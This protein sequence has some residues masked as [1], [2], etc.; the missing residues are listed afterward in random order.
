M[1]SKVGLALLVVSVTLLAFF[2][3]NR[4]PQ[5]KEVANEP[6]RA[7]QTN[8][9]FAANEELKGPLNAVCKYASEDFVAACYVRPKNLAAHEYYNALPIYSLVP[10][11]VSLTRLNEMQVEEL[12]VFAGTA[13]KDSKLPPES[14][15]SKFQL[16]LAGRFAERIEPQTLIA[17]WTQST[18]PSHVPEPTPHEEIKI[19]DRQCYRVPAG[20]FLECLPSFIVVGTL[21]VP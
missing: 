21:R 1:I 19:G 7:T 10:A 14:L 5:S 13:A 16:A 15:A 8:A 18:P 6:Q 4:T 12:V 9:L 11:S 17:N 2:A 3:T 20:T